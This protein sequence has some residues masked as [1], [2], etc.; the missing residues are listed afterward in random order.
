MKV[1]IIMFIICL[2]TG[3]FSLII[4]VDINGSTPFQLIQSGID[5]SVDGDTVLVHPGTYIENIIIEN[6]SIVLTSMEMITGDSTY[7]ENTIING[8]QNGSCI[9]AENFTDGIIQ[10]FTIQNGSGSSDGSY[11]VG[12]G[13]FISN[14]EICI[15]SCNIINNEAD[16]GGGCLIFHSTV[17][18][19]VII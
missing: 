2:Y 18:Y 11:Y 13:L 6:K 4:E 9:Y 10:G 5:V 14:S 8:N 7:I 17:I 19:Q 1:K 3:L 16:T 15:I 12:G